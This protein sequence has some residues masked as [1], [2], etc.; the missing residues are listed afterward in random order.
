MNEFDSGT[1]HIKANAMFELKQTGSVD[2]YKSQFDDLMYNIKLY[3][4]TE[5]G[6][7]WEVGHFVAGLKDALKTHVLSKLPETIS[8]AYHLAKAK[9][10]VMGEVMQGKKKWG[11]KIGRSKGGDKSKISTGDLWKAQQLKEYRR[12]HGLCFRCGE[13]YSPNHQCAQIPAAQV[14]V[15]ETIDHT[16]V[17]SDDILEAVMEV[18]D[19]GQNPDMFLSLN[20]VAG[21][22]NTG[23]IHL[24]AMVHNQ[25]LLIPV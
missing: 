9:E 23:T 6:T 12:I 15:V 17:L 20:A 3:D 13:K 19:L 8:Q 7:V 4:N 11:M 5:L 25:V 14:N 2:E 16:D 18:E 24:R 1:H 22:G 21:W 10:R